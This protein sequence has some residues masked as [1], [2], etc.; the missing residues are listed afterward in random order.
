MD[1][2]EDRRWWHAPTEVVDWFSHRVDRHETITNVMEQ[3]SVPEE[4]VLI[5]FDEHDGQPYQGAQDGVD[6]SVQAC[7]R[8]LRAG[9]VPLRVF[10]QRIRAFLS[11]FQY[12]HLIWVSARVS[13]AEDLE[14]IWVLAHEFRHLQQSLSCGELLLANW[15]L[16]SFLGGAEPHI[17][18]YANHVPTELDAELFAWR[19]CR[20]LCGHAAAD[21]YVRRQTAEGKRRHDFRLLVQQ[22][23]DRSYEAHTETIRLLTEH[24]K[25]LADLTRHVDFDIEEVCGRIST[26]HARAVVTLA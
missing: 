21:E 9:G 26:A 17:P 22:G 8:N 18:K 25:V 7:C 3:C 5:L 24:K 12:Q 4:G 6:W 16:C 23:L 10:P 11:E 19:I 14:F 20:E 2:A 13:R 1:R 15:Y